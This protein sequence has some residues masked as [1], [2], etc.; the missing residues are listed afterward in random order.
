MEKNKGGRPKIE[1]NSKDAEIFGHFKATFETM[2]EYYGCSIKT[3]QRQMQDEESEFCQSY[4]KALA[5]SKLKLSE[6]QWKCAIEKLN[7]TILIWL[8]KNHLGQSDGGQEITIKEPVKIQFVEEK[9]N[10]NNENT[11]PDNS[12]SESV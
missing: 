9:Q 5:K 3:I 11:I 2:A 10:E 8:G 6:A 4:K 12:E 7:P 1:L